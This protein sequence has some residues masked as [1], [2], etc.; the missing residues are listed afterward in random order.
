MVKKVEREVVR[1]AKKKKKKG[2]DENDDVM[3]IEVVFGN[4]EF[5]EI[6]ILMKCMFIGVLVFCFIV[7]DIKIINFFMGMGGREFIKDCDIEI[8]IGR[9][10]GLFG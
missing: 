4:V 9:R 2:D 10:Y 3:I 1:V 6:G 8:I 7:C 5:E